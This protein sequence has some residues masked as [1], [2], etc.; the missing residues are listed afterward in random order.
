V[1]VRAEEAGEVIVAGPLT[2][3]DRVA[4]SGTATLKA[5]WLSGGE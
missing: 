1:D 3:G 2:V 5:A 4:V